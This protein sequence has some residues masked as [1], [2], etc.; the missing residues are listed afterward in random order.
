M[1]SKKKPIKFRSDY[2]GDLKEI[3]LDWDYLIKIIHFESSVFNVFSTKLTKL[4]SC[5]I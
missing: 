3:D 1:I 4:F 2:E 5:V